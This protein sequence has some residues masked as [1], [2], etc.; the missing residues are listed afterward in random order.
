MARADDI[1]ADIER[2][3]SMPDA[4]FEERWGDWA[5]SQDRDLEMMRTRWVDDLKRM[6]P[7]AERE[8]EAGVELV[9]AKD[10]YRDDPSENNRL[11][12]DRAVAEIQQIRRD[13][14]AGRG[15][16]IAGDAFVNG[17]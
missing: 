12:R 9:A 6:L 16:A 8:D 11:R 2:I 17:A 15:M 4:E 10:A 1:R 7:H 3:E 14:R 13:K 5:R